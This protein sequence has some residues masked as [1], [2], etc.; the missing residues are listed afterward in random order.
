MELG[1]G[2]GYLAS[3]ILNTPFKTSDSRQV[4]SDLPNGSDPN[5]HEGNPFAVKSYT[6]TDCHPHVLEV[7]HHNLQ[8]LDKDKVRFID[9]YKCSNKSFDEHLFIRIKIKTAHVS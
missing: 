3:V 4:I 8:L 9:L 5:T 2:I 7:L 1:S 6:A